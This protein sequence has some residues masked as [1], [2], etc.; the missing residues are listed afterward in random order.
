MIS[1]DRGSKN[2]N[3]NGTGNGNN[4]YG[5]GIE[6]I[7]DRYSHETETHADLSVGA[8]HHRQLLILAL[9]ITL[10]QEQE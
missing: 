3:E 2:G 5:N 7:S 9:T 10:S 4:R 1:L 8:N 6:C